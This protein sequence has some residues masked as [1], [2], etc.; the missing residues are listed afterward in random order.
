M[1]RR[2]AIVP[3]AGAGAGFG[4]AAVLAGRAHPG[5][6]FA[7]ES[8]AAAALELAAGLALVAA[9]AAAWWRRPS[10]AFGPLLALAG[11]AWFVPEWNNPDAGGES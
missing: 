4:V 5:W 1:R 7:G 2:A 10:S 3:I 9:G 11:A 6:W 8:A